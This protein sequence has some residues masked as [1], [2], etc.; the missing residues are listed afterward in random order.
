MRVSQSI[1]RKHPAVNALHAVRRLKMPRF[2]NTG[3]WQVGGDF[4]ADPASRVI[5]R[6]FAGR[7]GGM[8][9]SSSDI[10]TR[11]IEARFNV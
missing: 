11:L 8:R 7:V 4:N 5:R 10:L 1:T 9:C 6:Y 3:V 2:V